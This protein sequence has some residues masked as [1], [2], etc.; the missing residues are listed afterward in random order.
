MESEGRTGVVDLRLGDPG[1]LC[2]RLQ[3]PR[4]QRLQL[5]RACRRLLVL[6]LRWRR[7]PG[8]GFGV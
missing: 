2:P 8:P 3:L 4:V 6:S 7:L 1:L 5:L